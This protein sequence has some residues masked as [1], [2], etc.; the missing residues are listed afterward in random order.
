MPA[1]SVFITTFNNART[2]PAC[3]ESVKWTDEIVVLDSFSSD[4]TL[5]IAARY[6]CRIIQHRF[7]G[8]GPQKQLALD[9]TS[10][11]WVLLLDADEALSPALQTE[12]RR[13]LETSPTASGYEIPRQ[14]QLFWRMASTRARMNYFLRL[15]DKTRGHVSDMPVHAAPKVEGSL[16]RLKH[17]FYHFGET[18]LH[19]KV[20]KL[21][22]Y[23]TGLVI[24]KLRRGKR[25]SP[26]MMVVYP[27]LVFVRSYLFKRS[28]MNGW[29][30][31]MNSV[32]MSFY[33]FMKYAKL[34]EHA[35]FARHGDTLM[36]PGAPAMPPPPSSP[37]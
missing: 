30:G 18:S 10:H 36:P 9:H 27:P 5:A 28:W 3:L 1:L 13:L 24:D 33:A 2:L 4:E 23:S 6:N 12:I 31:L 32:S 35:Q 37:S 21:N 22:A 34:Y 20:E 14:E 19:V 11:Q 16:A 26:W 25:V 15:F 29:A 8:Y 7:L 17:P